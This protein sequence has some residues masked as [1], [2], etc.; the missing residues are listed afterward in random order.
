MGGPNDKYTACRLGEARDWL[1][2]SPGK[3]PTRCG[4]KQLEHL[5]AK[6]HDEEG[7]TQRPR[8]HDLQIM[9][10]DE[11]P[12]GSVDSSDNSRPGRTE[13]PAAWKLNN[14]TV[15]ADQSVKFVAATCSRKAR[16]YAN[17]T[18]PPN[19]RYVR[20]IKSWYCS[21]SLHR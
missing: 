20:R 18:R 1:G 10:E 7:A 11:A 16:S 19:W 17:Q 13:A 9:W 14:W 8:F 3:A 6:R 21:K 5:C 12:C 4:P 2:G 15:M